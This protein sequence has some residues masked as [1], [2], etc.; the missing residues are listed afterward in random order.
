MCDCS[1]N[2]VEGLGSAPQ[3]TIDP[4]EYFDFTTPGKLISVDAC[5]ETQIRA[6]WKKGVWTG[7]CCCGHNN[8]FAKYGC[9]VVLQDSADPVEAR[10]VLTKSDPKRQWTILQ[11]KLTEV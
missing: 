1:S 7:G 5:I 8:Y 4:N 3:V 2:N 10:K 9:N 6:L 11:W